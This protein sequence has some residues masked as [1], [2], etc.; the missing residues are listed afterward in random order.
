MRSYKRLYATFRKMRYRRLN[1]FPR[2]S[3]ESPPQF[4]RIAKVLAGGFSGGIIEYRA[5]AWLWRRPELVTQQMFF[6]FLVFRRFSSQSASILTIVMLLVFISLAGCATGPKYET[7]ASDEPAAFMNESSG[8][9]SPP[10]SGWRELFRSP[11][12]NGLLDQAEA[13]NLTLQAAWQ[14][15]L[16]SRATIQRFRA[17]G[18]PQVDAGLSGE[19]FERSDALSGI[20]F[21]GAGDRFDADGRASWEL[22]LFGRVRRSVEAAKAGYEAEKALYDD[23]MFTLQADV[24]LHYFQI[25]SLQA[26]IEL[27]ERSQETRAESLK[28]IEQRRRAGTVSELAVAQTASLLATAEARLYAAQRIQNS[29]LYS[30]AALLGE[31]PAT[32]AYEPKALKSSPPEIPGGL[33]GELLARRPDIR[34]S[35][36]S[37]AEAN[38]LVG[39]AKAN[40]F[41][42][43]TLS[44]TLGYAARDWDD[45][46]ESISRFEN[47]GAGVSVPVFQGG[48]LR[49][50]EAQARA[51]FEERSLRYRQTVI[52]AVTEVEDFL[53]SVRLLE[54]QSQ[55]VA[56]SVAASS[57]ARRISTL[58]YEQGVSDFI[59]AL[60]AERTALDA[61]QQY[62]Q[63][64][65]SQYVDTINLVRALGGGW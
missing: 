12:L 26:E 52:S 62:E 40:Y 18:L 64:R 48:R 61:E 30:L 22:D 1:Q 6:D 46:F 65:R 51:L 25:N 49:A 37:L 31:T 60:D 57:N 21:G 44:G 33:P 32:F 43:I 14:S 8:T 58:Q 55:A 42:R 54:S 28:L 35:E 16:A 59:T 39:V 24:A 13:N 4:L 3:Q 11:G 50:N 47:A 17:A 45:M 15:V 63:V 19:T 9:G 10:M 7:P 36:R 29:L 53:Q 27:L 2:N 23:L 20:G 41:P 5:V 56:R 38:A 34:R